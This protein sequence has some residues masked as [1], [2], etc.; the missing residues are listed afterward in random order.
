[1]YLD[2]PITRNNI[3]SQRLEINDYQSFLNQHHVIVEQI[4]RVCQIS[5]K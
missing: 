4:T 1:M 3:T 2:Y 5:Q